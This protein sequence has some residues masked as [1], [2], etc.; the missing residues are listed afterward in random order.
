[1]IYDSVIVTFNRKEKLIMA[2]ESLLQQTK[3]PNKI[4]VIDNHSTDGTYDLLKEKGYLD[5]TILNYNV[6]PENVGGSGGF[7]YGIQKAVSDTKCDFISI[8]DDDAIFE[9][10]FFTKINDASHSNPDIKA[11]CGTVEFENGNIQTDHRRVILNEKWLSEAE[12]PLKQYKNNFFV[13]TFSFVGCVIN[14]SIIKKIGL[15][16]KEFFIYYDDTEYSLRVREETKILNV[17]DAVIKHLITPTKDSK[18]RIGWKNYYEIRNKT[19]MK[20]NHSSWP[21]INL[22]LLFNQ[23][24]LNYFVITNPSFKG[25]RKKSIMIYNRGFIDGMKGITGKNPNFLPG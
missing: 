21:W 11:F 4:I 25:I 19:I 7:Y 18:K 24:R 3:K 15:P 9:K 20:K 16:R 10:D 1:M 22:Y 2:I 17:S 6:L 5:N 8:S 14:R 13:D 23:A 12:V